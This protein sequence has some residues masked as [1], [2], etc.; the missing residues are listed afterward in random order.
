MYNIKYAI[1]KI[2]VMNRSVRNSVIIAVWFL[3]IRDFFKI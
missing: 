3:K 2:L 1:Y